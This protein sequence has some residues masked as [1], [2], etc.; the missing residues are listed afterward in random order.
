MLLGTAHRMRNHRSVGGPL[1]QIMSACVAV[2]PDAPR[3]GRR[4]GSTETHHSLGDPSCISSPPE[5]REVRDSH[6]SS[7]N[8]S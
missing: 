2:Y 6:K 5:E 1:P 3:K 4:Q 8:R 7:F